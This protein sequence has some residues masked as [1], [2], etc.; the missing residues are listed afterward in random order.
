MKQYMLA[1]IVLLSGCT[2][3]IETGSPILNKNNK[4]SKN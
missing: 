2:T 3:P 1:L 4:D